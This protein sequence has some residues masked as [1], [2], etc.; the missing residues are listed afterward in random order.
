MNNTNTSNITNLIRRS[1]EICSVSGEWEST[2]NYITTI[3]VSRNQIM[4]LYC[5]INVI[6]KLIRRG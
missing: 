1:G 2:G 3:I 6:W 5:G 4:P